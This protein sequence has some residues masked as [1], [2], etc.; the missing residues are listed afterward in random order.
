[1]GVLPAAGLWL[2]QGGGTLGETAGDPPGC[3]RGCG[4][5]GRGP[6]RFIAPV[7]LADRDH[8]SGSANEGHGPPPSG[9]PAGGGPRARSRQ[10]RSNS[11]K[12]PRPPVNG[13]AGVQAAHI[14][15]VTTVSYLNSHETVTVARP[16]ID[17]PDRATAR[18]RVTRTSRRPYLTPTRHVTGTVTSDSD[19]LI[20][21]SLAV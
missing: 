19:L 16:L 15:V 17:L 6:G 4:P 18:C 11:V 9:P 14:H 20:T 7:A 10:S 2:G 21:Q 3:R 12:L 8:G 5:G 13:S 1:M